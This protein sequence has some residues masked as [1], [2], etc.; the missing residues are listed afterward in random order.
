MHEKFS[1]I[2][3]D[4]EVLNVIDLER[5]RSGVNY[6]GV[7]LTFGISD[8]MTHQVFDGSAYV[9]NYATD[10]LT[11]A[12]SYF[13][14]RSAVKLMAFNIPHL[15]EITALVSGLGVASSFELAQKWGIY[16]GTYDVRDF[17]AYAAGASLAYGIDR[18]VSGKENSKEIIIFEDK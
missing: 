12:A 15:K 8:V 2:I 13:I 1:S 9:D 18:L 16:R 17:F 6:A 10:N 7:A 4:N 14:A 3:K 5:V 11:T